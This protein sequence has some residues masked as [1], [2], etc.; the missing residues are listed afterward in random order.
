M[1]GKNSGLIKKCRQSLEELKDIRV[2]AFCGVLMAMSIVL[3][4]IATIRIGNYIRIGFS[5]IPNRVADDLFGPVVG[6]I[7]GA[8][9]D[10]VS[11]FI[12][13]TGDFFPGFTLTAVVGSAVFGGILY[14]RKLTVVRVLTAQ[15]FIKIVC[16][17]CLNSIWL[18]LLYGQGILAML[19]GRIISNAVM[20]PVDT[21]ICYVVLRVVRPVAVR[22]F[23]WENENKETVRIGSKKGV[24]E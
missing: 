14:R 1:S 16:N 7:F 18:K 12:N 10:V 19:P 21:A 9:R 17:I 22:M 3:G 5:S 20:L 4:L 6:M 13:P 23:G 11:W 15:L 24:N 2:V 8:A